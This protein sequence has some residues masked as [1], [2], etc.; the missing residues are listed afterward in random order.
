MCWMKRK[1]EEELL[2]VG[3][4]NCKTLEQLCEFVV[5]MQQV[6]FS[7]AC[8]DQ[9]A[10]TRIGHSSAATFPLTAR[11]QHVSQTSQLWAI[12][13]H[14]GGLTGSCRVVWQAH[15]PLPC[16]LLVHTLQLLL[17]IVSVLFTALLT[18]S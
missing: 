12:R 9:S 15:N 13:Q 11:R 18:C 10:R 17:C 5:G 6:G 7:H 4:S 16:R 8:L 14:L 1:E 2:R 3:L